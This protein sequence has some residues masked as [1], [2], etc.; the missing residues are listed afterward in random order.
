VHRLNLFSRD[1][2]KKSR[3]QVA[4]EYLIILGFVAIIT[5]PL[6]IIFHT[7]SKETTAEITSAQ[8]YQ[9]S[10][11]ISDGAETV[12]YLGEPSKLTIKTYFPRNVNSILIGSN[13]IVFNVKAGERTDEIV[14]YTPINVS[15]NIS[16][17]E[18]VHYITIESK[19]GYVWISG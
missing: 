1:K 6:A 13:E 14:V 16:T 12:F 5:I 4:M 2:G 9:I 11:R 17:Y 10:K 15:G 8:I 18:G 7:H 3:A 19:G